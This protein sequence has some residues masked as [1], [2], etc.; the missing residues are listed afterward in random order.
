M[1]LLYFSSL[2]KCHLSLWQSCEETSSQPR[3]GLM[4][5]TES[6][7]KGPEKPLWALAHPS[8]CPGAGPALP[9]PVPREASPAHPQRAPGSLELLFQ[10]LPIS[11]IKQLFLLSNLDLS[12]QFKAITVCLIL[13]GSSEKEKKKIFFS[14]AHL[15]A[16]INC[17][18][19]WP[20]PLCCKQSSWIILLPHQKLFLLICHSPDL[21]HQFASS[22]RYDAAL[23]RPGSTRT[24]GLLQFLTEISP[25]LLPSARLLLSKTTRHGYSTF[26]LPAI[27][28]P[29]L[30]AIFLCR[31]WG[32]RTCHLLTKTHFTD[33]FSKLSNQFLWSQLHPCSPS[34]LGVISCHLTRSYN[35]PSETSALSNPGYAMF[36]FFTNHWLFNLWAVPPAHWSKIKQD[37]LNFDNT[38]ALTSH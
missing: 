37:T 38:H 19:P 15:K 32:R 29:S 24:E 17:T 2:Q 20:S 28:R 18:L 23:P 14:F 34:Q 36:Q 31:S 8:L 16:P 9:L 22:L 13:W 5:G 12:L 25:H 33:D 21:F 30:L 35:K 10:Y 7:K 1:D 27:Q 11:T 4:M 6:W 26:R 3:S